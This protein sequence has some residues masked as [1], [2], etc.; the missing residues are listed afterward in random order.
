VPED[1]RKGRRLGDETK[2]RIA[3]LASGWT[4]GGDA[5]PAPAPPLRREPTGPSRV[6]RDAAQRETRPPPPPGSAARRVLE[7]PV[8]P[9][10]T[11]EPQPQPPPPSLGSR[12]PAPVPASSSGSRP[13]PGP[14]LPPGRPRSGQVPL[15]GKARAIRA[16]DPPDLSTLPEADRTKENRGAVGIKHGKGSSPNNSS[17]TTNA[18]S[19]TIGDTP[20]PIFDRA[21]IAAGQKGALATER[22]G[23][24]PPDGN[25][26]TTGTGP[27][28]AVRGTPRSAAP[29]RPAPPDPPSPR[30]P[31]VIV[32]DPDDSLDDSLRGA[33]LDESSPRGA[34]LAVPVG[35]F[36]GDGDEEDLAQD[37]RGAY[38]QETIQRNAM[39]AL[40]GLAEQDQTIPPPPARAAPPPAPPPAPPLPPPPAPPRAG[41]KFNEASGSS[42]D[43]FERDD[44]G[45]PTVG[46][47][48]G[49][50]TMLSPSAPSPASAGTLRNSSALPRKRGLAGD[51]RYVA[52]VVFGVRAANREIAALEAKQATRQQSR[53][54]HLVTLGRTAVTRPEWLDGGSP[55]RER[56]G[57]GTGDAAE[58]PAVGPA[59]DQLAAVEHERAQQAEQV[60]A[61]DVELT[62]VRRDREDKANTYRI[63]STALDTELAAIAK[64]LEPLDK[65][66]VGIQRR[67]ADLQDAR[68]RIDGKIASTEASLT[69]ARA[70][71]LDRAAVQAELATLKAE[72]KTIQRDEPVIAGQLDALS[73]RIAALEAARSEAQ[74]RRAELE[75]AEQEDQ[76]RAEEML[77]AIGAK[78]KVVDRA[79]SDAEALRDKILFQLGERLYVDRPG[80]LKGQLAPIDEIDV[81]LGEADRRMM[82]LR[83]LIATIDKLKIARGLALI[84]VI[85]GAI[86][87]LAVWLLVVRA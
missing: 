43:R 87:A 16:D 46:D 19:G 47:E 63:D 26:R 23:D 39:T 6:A 51:M 67:A 1:E 42:T 22:V 56:P 85:L 70:E 15:T 30:P 53:R 68:R 3:D 69:S 75:V 11:T 13:P 79:A 24:R 18:A 2:G 35:E 10:S 31:P 4:V 59:R 37:H 9:R 34:A 8:D 86:G 71:K 41:A 55:R 73:P 74:R 83:E 50:A 84:L 14:P 27:N 48:R 21:A 7:D 76:R 52:T 72:R 61:A 25:L 29:A 5:P 80:D 54:R 66:A 65:E 45:D 77:V 38:G 20:P 60:A 57:G 17:L 81:E 78:R 64:K 36:G 62:R 58:H 12:P 32:D 82:E 33:F 28:A 44:R 40:L 49:D